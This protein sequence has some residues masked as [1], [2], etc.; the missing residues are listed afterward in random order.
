MIHKEVTIEN[1]LQELGFK[2]AP[3]KTLWVYKKLYVHISD[4]RILDPKGDIIK[5]ENDS[6]L[7]KA[8][9]TWKKKL[10]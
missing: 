8:V 1:F 4:R 10:T 5:Y 6:E 7:L 3:F 9:L 2:N